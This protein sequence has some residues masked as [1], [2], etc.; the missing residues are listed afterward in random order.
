MYTSLQLRLICGTPDDPLFQ[1]NQVGELLGIVNVRNTI[2]EFD[3][4]EKGV[5]S[6]YTLGGE[7]KLVFLTEV[8][9]YRLIGMSRKPLARPFQ[10]WVAAVIKEIR[11]RT[12]R[13]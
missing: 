2:K 10:R 4:S 7:Q 1:A 6:V 5:H 9:L 11:R 8:G 12:R 13:G 3:E